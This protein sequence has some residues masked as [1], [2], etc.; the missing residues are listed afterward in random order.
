MEQQQAGTIILYVRGIEQAS[1]WAKVQELLSQLGGVQA[2]SEQQIPGQDGSQALSKQ[3]LVRYVPEQVAPE[4]MVA[5]LEDAGFA[6]P[7]MEEPGTAV[8]QANPF[9]DLKTTAPETR[10]WADLGLG[11]PESGEPRATRSE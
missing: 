10:A 3:V 1:D 11:Q 7:T 8:A 5:A 2:V 9:D 6:V 4:Q